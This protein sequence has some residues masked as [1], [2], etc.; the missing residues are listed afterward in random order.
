MSFTGRRLWI[1]FAGDVAEAF[2]K[3]EAMVILGPGAEL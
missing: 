1:N 2:A 3:A